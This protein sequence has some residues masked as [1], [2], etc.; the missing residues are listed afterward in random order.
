MKKIQVRDSFPF[1]IQPSFDADWP[2]SWRE[3]YHYDCLEVWNKA[4]EIDS[5]SIGYV[6]GYTSRRQQTIKAVLDS[7]SV[8]GRVLDLAAAQGNFTIAL[9]SL[10]YQVTWNDLRAEL[11][12]YVRLKTPP[13]V[14][15]DYLAGNIFELGDTHIGSFDAVVALEVIEHVAHPD[16]FVMKLASLVKPGGSIILSTPNG[17]YLLNKLPRFSDCP[18]PT[19]FESQQFKLAHVKTLLA[20]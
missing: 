17:G 7:C 6:S 9:A 2:Q 18:D 10:G 19:I 12:E 16:D 8:P 20:G 1:P 14:Q 5:R 4:T 15:I 13:G 11:A 3:S